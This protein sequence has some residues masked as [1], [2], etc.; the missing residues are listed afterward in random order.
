M[1]KKYNKGRG[2]NGSRGGG[3]AK[4][5]AKPTVK[6]GSKA[7]TA[8]FGKI[9]KVG[10]S[11]I[12]SAYM[13][14]GTILRRLQLTLKDFRR[15]C[16][17]KGIYPRDPPKTPTAGKDKVYY[18]ATDIQ[19]L[20]HEPLLQE[21][22][23]FKS[24]MV[25]VRRSVG[26]K[27]VDRARARYEEAPIYDVHHLVKER[28]PTFDSALKDLDDALCT[29]ALFASL[30]AAGRL[31]PEAT[32][33]CTKVL[34]WWQQYV[35]HTGSLQKGFISVKGVYFQAEV[36]KH[37]ITW[38][39]PHAYTQDIPKK[40][41]FRVMLTFLEFYTAYVKFILFRLYKEA[42]LAF[43]P[44]SCDT[45]SQ[46]L[47]LVGSEVEGPLDGVSLSLR[48]EASYSWLDFACAAS[49][50]TI[51]E[52]PNATHIIADRPLKE[53]DASKEHVQ[54]QWVMDSLNKEK[55]Q[56]CA[57][58][59]PGAVAPPHLSPFVEEEEEVDEEDADD[60]SDG[61]EDAE[62][63]PKEAKDMAK[64]LMSKKAKRLYGRMQHG[65]EKK[66]AAVTRLRKRRELLEARAARN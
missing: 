36:Q 27:D 24:A 42:G 34:Q 18:H 26:R 60:A 38:L 57:P 21:F 53:S 10:A 62:A 58:Y 65:K 44:A 59:A 20:A 63:T 25:K 55:A 15:L 6:K 29:I 47:A 22:R 64:M 66:T 45:T 5:A 49:G 7:R 48:R 52:E 61:E 14:R 11:G 56:P 51:V 54:P 40:V 4:H 2:G 3:T 19:Q 39:V 16:I 32:A 41:D 8:G 13:T 50:A 17:L 23:E 28:Y 12:N 37:S 1:G 31:Q 46:F 9:S 33:E 30:P 35:A 43:P